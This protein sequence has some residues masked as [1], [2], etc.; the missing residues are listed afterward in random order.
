VPGGGLQEVMIACKT[1]RSY[2]PG[3]GREYIKRKKY[4]GNFYVKSYVCNE[5]V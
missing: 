2:S 4:R 1:F 5:K 3:N